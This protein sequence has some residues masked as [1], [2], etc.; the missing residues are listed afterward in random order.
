MTWPYD[1]AH[2]HRRRLPWTLGRLVCGLGLA[3]SP[4]PAAGQHWQLDANATRIAVDTAAA[5]GSASLAPTIEW[6]NRRLYG[7]VSGSV[8]GFDGSTW[9]THGRSE[10]AVFVEPFGMLHPLRFEAVGAGQGTYHSTAFRTATGRG[11]IRLHL[12][13]RGLGAWIGGAAAT[14]WTSADRV[15]VSGLGGSAGV[16][17]RGGGVQAVALFTPLRLEGTWFPEASGRV[18]ALAG[19]VD[20]MAFGGWRA[21]ADDVESALWGGIV[22]TAWITDRVAVVAG[23]GAYPGDLLQGLPGGRYVSAGIR[24]A[25]GRPE[26][27]LREPLG[28]PV[29]VEHEG[30]RALRFEVPGARQVAFVGEWSGWEPIPLERAPEG[31]TIWMLYIELPTGVHRFNLV[32]DGERWIVPAGVMTVADGFGGE[33]GLLIVP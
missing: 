13:G 29:Y 32:V 22:A 20:L 10:L 5:V 26:A 25:R 27:P 21:G 3:A 11:E 12:A 31:G 16:W 8:T 28:R 23:G 7:L 30:R 18:A 1:H 6:R 19:P 14:G 17:T 9:A 24:I 4:A 2:T 33:V 15:F